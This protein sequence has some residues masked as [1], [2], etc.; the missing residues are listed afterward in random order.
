MIS[1]WLRVSARKRRLLIHITTGTTSRRFAGFCW[2][3]RRLA[4]RL[5]QSPPP[6]KKEHRAAQVKY[7]SS[8]S[9]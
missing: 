8:I 5:T 9:I 1:P 6:R 2:Q 7:R 3:K 4:P